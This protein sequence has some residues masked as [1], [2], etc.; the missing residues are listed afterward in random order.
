MCYKNNHPGAVFFFLQFFSKL[1][2]QLTTRDLHVADF[3]LIGDDFFSFSFYVAAKI[4][5]LRLNV[6]RGAKNQFRNFKLTKKE[7]TRE[8]ISKMIKNQSSG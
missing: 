2:K 1:L 5:A 8:S 3:I 4:Y 7:V 6:H